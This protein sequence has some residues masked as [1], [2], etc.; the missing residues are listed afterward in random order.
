MLNTLALM[1]FG[2]TVYGTRVP[3]SDKDFKGIYLPTPEE[4]IMG[5]A[6]RTFHISTKVDQTAKS[7]ADDQETEVFALKEYIRLLVEGQTVALTMLFMPDKHIL[8]SS[9]IW[10]FIR[11]N[12]SEFLHSGV[13]AFAGYCKQQANKYGIKG[14]RVA[15]ARAASEFLLGLKPTDRLR[16]HWPVIEVW[17]S[18]YGEHISIVHIE[19]EEPMLEVCNRRIQR[20]AKLSAASELCDRIFKE[21]GARAIQAESNEGIDW[22]AC[23][24]AVRVAAEAKELLLTHHITYPRP[25]AETL[26]QIRKGKLPYK[27]VAEMIEQGL[28]EL[29]AASAVSTLPKEPDKYFADGFVYDTYLKSILEEAQYGYGH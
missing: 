6:R 1:E 22:K 21:Y 11:A 26:L 12:K 5:T 24:H 3:T 23:M 16:D 28:V 17:A 15:A 20:G 9:P 29:D 4:I 14:S 7:G 2:S 13:T 10:E 25:E 8:K 18:Q 19:H 27:Q